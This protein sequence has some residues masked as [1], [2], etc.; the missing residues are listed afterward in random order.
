MTSGGGQL[1]KGRPCSDEEER[2]WG[3]TYEGGE[4]GREEKRAREGGRRDIS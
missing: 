1:V 2:G 4:G 3:Y